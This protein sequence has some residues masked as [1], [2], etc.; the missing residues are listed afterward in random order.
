MKTYY[1]N[2]GVEFGVNPYLDETAFRSPKNV[3]HIPFDCEDVP[4]YAKLKCLCDSPEIYGDDKNI[5][6]REVFNTKIL[7]K[8]AIFTIT[9]E[10]IQRSK[11]YENYMKIMDSLNKK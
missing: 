7:S 8:C 4:I 11:N 10:D 2:T 6:V 9:P 1:F 5:I 3:M